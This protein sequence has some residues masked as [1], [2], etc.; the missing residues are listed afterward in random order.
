MFCRFSEGKY[1]AD[2]EVLMSLP[3]TDESTPNSLNGETSTLN[4]IK[5]CKNLSEYLYR[6]PHS[7]R[8]YTN[9]FR[10]TVCPGLITSSAKGQQRQDKLRASH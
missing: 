4:Q 1:L 9:P 10:L 5:I 6:T 7:I 8:S 2:E 3:G